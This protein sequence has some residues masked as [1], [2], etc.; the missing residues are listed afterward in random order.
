MNLNEWLKKQQTDPDSGMEKRAA[1]NPALAEMSLEELE[2]SMRKLGM[3]LPFAEDPDKGDEEF[4]Q[5]LAWADTTGREL[6]RMEKEAS[7]AQPLSQRDALVRVLGRYPHLNVKAHG[8]KSRG[9][10][11]GAGTAL[12][13]IIGG[14]SARKTGLRGL[15]GAGV[16]ALVGAASGAGAGHIY[17]RFMGDKVKRRAV[18]DVLTALGRRPLSKTAEMQDRCSRCS[19]PCEG[20]FCDKCK[21]ALPVS[22]TAEKKASILSAYVEKAAGLGPEARRAIAAEA[23]QELAKVAIAGGMLRGA[24]MAGLAGKAGGKAIRAASKARPIGAVSPAAQAQGR[25]MS[26]L[27][28]LRTSTVPSPAGVRY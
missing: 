25:A 2:D 28:S 14:I 4:K 11:A 7:E 27:K 10:G 5:K 26:K 22:A 9:V 18:G 6:A 8:A 24:A 17:S 20:N 3:Q 16:G 15:T 13:A 12:G 1:A 23:G 21:K 19:E